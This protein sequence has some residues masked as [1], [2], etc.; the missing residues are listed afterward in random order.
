MNLQLRRFRSLFKSTDNRQTYRLDFPL[1]E[2][3]RSL[4]EREHCTPD[5]IAA[6]L[7]SLALEQRDKSENGLLA[8]TSLSIREQ[9]IVA[10]AC[11]GYTNQLIAARIHLS[12]ETVK[13]HLSN[14]LHKYGLHRKSELRLAL[15][16]WDFSA[17]DK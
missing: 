11:L 8:W 14:A 16:G 15:A 1:S 6:N 17:W 10:L 7:I 12:P 3:I 2:K 13:T 4:A 5:E 9:Q